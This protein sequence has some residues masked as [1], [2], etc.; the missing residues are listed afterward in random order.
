MNLVKALLEN[1]NALRNAGYLS[2]EGKDIFAAFDEDGNMIAV[3]EA[4]AYISETGMMMS[5]YLADGSPRDSICGE[6]QKIE[7]LYLLPADLKFE[8]NDRISET[9]NKAF[10]LPPAY[11]VGQVVCEDHVFTIS[12]KEANPPV[13][14]AY[15]VIKQ[16]LFSAAHSYYTRGLASNVL[17]RYYYEFL[18]ESHQLYLEEK[19]FKREIKERKKQKTERKKLTEE[20]FQKDTSGKY[21]CEKKI[22]LWGVTTTLY[23][24]FEENSE[25]KEC[26]LKEYIDQVNVHILWIE[27]HR[28]EIEKALLKANMAETAKAWMDGRQVSGE[29]G[30]TYY[31]LDDGEFF[32]FPITESSFLENLFIQSIYI[33]GYTSGD[34]RIQL[35]LDT[36]PNFFA[37]HIIEVFIHVD[38]DTQKP[39][40]AN[41]KYRIH[42]G[43]LAG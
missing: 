28:K 33:D 17:E 32:P 43:G 2:I 13:C 24:D 10:P 22:K 26:T 4:W 41:R 8:E 1:R 42:V 29:D 16:Q 27:K 23:T 39:A 7:M 31:E 40:R 12:S 34:T 30:Q 25:N 18:P 15:D 5:E 20:N 19:T 11:G 38:M 14:G 21:T 36:V 9:E 37:E 35:F 3:G 6:K